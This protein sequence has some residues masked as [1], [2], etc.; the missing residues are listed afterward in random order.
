MNR[1]KNLNSIIHD[2]QQLLAA[3]KVYH[4]ASAEKIRTIEHRLALL[5]LNQPPV[6]DDL[7]IQE[8]EQVLIAD[9]RRLSQEHIATI[10]DEGF[11]IILDMTTHCL[12]YRPDPTAH[13]DLMPSDLKGVGPHRIHIL[14]SMLERPGRPLIWENCPQWFGDTTYMISPEALTK[15]ISV[16]RQALGG[17]GKENPYIIDEPAWALSAKKRARAYAANPKWKYLVIR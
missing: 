3:E 4:E 14:K 15:A 2:F 17:E 16:L 7:V 13:T 8:A 10:N 11:D 9:G 5:Q 1:D 6:R 12:R